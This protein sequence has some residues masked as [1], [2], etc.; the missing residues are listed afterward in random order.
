MFINALQYVTTVVGE[1]EVKTLIDSGAQI[2]VINGKFLSQGKITTG[3]IILTSAFGERIEAGLAKF[4]VSL[5]SDHKDKFYRP[6]E[7]LAAVSSRI[8]EQLIIP[9]NIYQLLKSSTEDGGKRKTKLLQPR[10]A[11]KRT[12]GELSVSRSGGFGELRKEIERLREDVER[13]RRQRIPSKNE[14]VSTEKGSE[15]I[16]SEKP[17]KQP[18]RC[19]TENPLRAT[20]YGLADSE[21]KGGHSNTCVSDNELSNDEIIGKLTPA[22]MQSS[23]TSLYVFIVFNM[24]IKRMN[25]PTQIAILVCSNLALKI[26]KLAAS[27]K[28]IIANELVTGLP[29]QTIANTEYEDNLGFETPTSSS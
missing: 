9:T 5:K 28:Q 3:K 21:N 27:L 18:E 25:S 22:W 7:I 26:C 12:N 24:Y 19:I 1:K 2:L 10:L 8:Q 4:L 20:A 23:S 14:A 16:E 13:L 29:S 6:I 17:A 11:V 15:D